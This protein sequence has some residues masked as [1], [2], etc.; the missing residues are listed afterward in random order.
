MRALTHRFHTRHDFTPELG[1]ETFRLLS[2]FDEPTSTAG[3]KA[4]ADQLG[5]PLRHRKGVEKILASLSDVL[6]VQKQ[7]DRYCLTSLGEK[8]SS[9]DTGWSSVFKAAVHSLYYW[10][11]DDKY[12]VANPSWSYKEVCRF[13]REKGIHGVTADEIV[14]YVTL[15]AKKRFNCRSVS[16]SRSSVAGVTGWLMAL[17]PPLVISQNGRLR[18]NPLVSPSADTVDY[19]LAGASSYFGNPIVLHPLVLDLIGVSLLM[20]G[21]QVL[22]MFGANQANKASVTWLGGDPPAILIRSRALEI[23][24]AIA[25]NHATNR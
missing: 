25:R 21:D 12:I 10:L 8:F 24:Q 22:E 3:L 23:A 6:L 1:W 17:D 7:E 15:S 4:L 5:S 19:A 16:F 20:S 2:L 11:W 18:I 14:I 9:L 13:I